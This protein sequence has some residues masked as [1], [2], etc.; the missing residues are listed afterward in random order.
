MKPTR[1][2][3]ARNLRVLRELRGRIGQLD[4]AKQIGVSRRTVA[5][6]ESADVADPGV[7]QVRRLADSLGV[8]MELLATRELRAV[9]LPLPVE[10]AAKLEGK[11]GAALLDAVVMALE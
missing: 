10:L 9:T 11:D 3:L 1:D 5:R 2:I 6:L 8:S 7:D 4:L